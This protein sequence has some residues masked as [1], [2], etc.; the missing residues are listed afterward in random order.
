M[1]PNILTCWGGDGFNQQIRFILNAK[2]FFIVLD[3]HSKAPKNAYGMLW[4]DHCFCQW[5]IPSPS[6]T[7]L[8]YKFLV[9]IHFFDQF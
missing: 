5:I 3:K 8:K 7:T 1:E 2:T 9:E 6:P 4:H